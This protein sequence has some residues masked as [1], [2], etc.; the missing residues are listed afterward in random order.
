MPDT[1]GGPRRAACRHVRLD[2]VRVDRPVLAEAEWR[3]NGVRARFT[4]GHEVFVPSKFFHSG[5]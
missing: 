3:P 5:R 2:S 1:R 4:S